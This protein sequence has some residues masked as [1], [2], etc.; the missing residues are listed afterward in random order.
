MTTLDKTF[1]WLIPALVIVTTA[2]FVHVGWRIFNPPSVEVHKWKTMAIPVQL[3]D[4]NYTLF[5]DVEVKDGK[6]THARVHDPAW[7]PWLKPEPTQ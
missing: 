4:T 7:L 3:D 2:L 6:L 1:N 5:W